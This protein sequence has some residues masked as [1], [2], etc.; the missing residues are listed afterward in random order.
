[1]EI[2]VLKGQGSLD[3]FFELK[4]GDGPFEEKG[5]QVGEQLH[6]FG[7]VHCSNYK[8]HCTTEQYIPD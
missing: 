4:E 7:F 2:E 1:M 6:D 8:S 5:I 3:A